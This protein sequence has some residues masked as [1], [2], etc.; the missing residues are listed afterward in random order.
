[1]HFEAI[2]LEDHFGSRRVC[3]P[4]ED[5]LHLSRIEACLRHEHV[6]GDGK[7]PE[8]GD[9]ELTSLQR[10]ST[11]LCT[12]LLAHQGHDAT[13]SSFDVDSMVAKNGNE[14]RLRADRGYLNVR[15]VVAHNA[16]DL[17]E[18]LGKQPVKL[19]REDRGVSRYDQLALRIGYY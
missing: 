16:L 19:A 9:I 6:E 18:S 3:Y 11:E 2:A 1:M 13:Y 8:R 12:D 7:K 15:P 10:F 14:T 5:R 4:F 17:F